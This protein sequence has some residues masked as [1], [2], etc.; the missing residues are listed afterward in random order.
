MRKFALTVLAAVIVLGAVVVV[1][2]LLHGPLPPEAAGTASPRI[3]I[4]ADDVARHL[5][6]AIRFRTV[7][8]EPPAPIDA[9]QFE[10]F[11]A[12][13]ATTYPDAMAA[14][15]PRRVGYSLLLTWQGSEPDAA[16]IL[17]TAH[18]DVVPVIAG[19]ESS[20]QQ[21]PFA[22]AVV[23][24]VIWG[25]GALDDKSAV[26]AQLEAADALVRQGFHPQRTVYFSFGHDEELGGIN[27]AAGVV[28]LLRGENVRL[29]WT[30]DEG[31]FLFDDLI[32][33]VTQQ[34]APIN[35]AEKGIM[36]LDIIA[37]GQ[38]GHSSMPPPSTAVGS[39]AAA[40]VELEAHPLPG[41]LDALSEQFWDTTSRYMPFGMR[42]VFANRWLF[43]PLI[44]RQLSASP[45]GNAMLRTT[46]APTML[47]GS[48]KSNVLPIEAVA[49]VNFRLHPRDSSA[50]VVEFVEKQVADDDISVRVVRA[51]EAS[52]VSSWTAPG[53]A[54][55]ADAV[56]SVYGDVVVVPGLM[57][58]ASDSKHYG[59]IAD[60]SYRFKPMRVTQADL[61]GFHGTNEKL[62]LDTLVRAVHTYA[63]IIQQGSQT[64]K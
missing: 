24:G 32:P 12:W 11:L 29:A 42:L 33:G 10:A 30:L 22:G 64:G 14:L 43:G 55:V 38:G 36:N 46:I 45:F 57:V 19:T 8:V 62:A 53:Y 37:H 50:H 48:P 25:R 27:G 2:T 59:E 18:Y 3:D 13:V 41:G 58:A 56:R 1:Q 23:D 5:A 63:A 9:A 54:T 40:I 28:S 15:Q 49:T 21:P 44:E 6:E 17:L 7:S 4:A 61:T 35:V 60:N 47:R 20:W 31:S 16:P 52:A 39:L 26:I 34:F 51:V